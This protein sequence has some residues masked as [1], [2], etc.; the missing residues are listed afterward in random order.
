M[1]LT[2]SV[3]MLTPPLITQGARQDSHGA[4][5]TSADTLL[6]NASAP[7]NRAD[8]PLKHADASLIQELKTPM[9]QGQSTNII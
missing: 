7:L 8:A 9:A 5:L 3:D 4:F 2:L 1:I 6:N